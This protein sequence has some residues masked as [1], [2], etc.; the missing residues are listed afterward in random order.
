MDIKKADFIKK[1]WG[2]KPCKHPQLE[3]EYIMGSSTGDYICVQCGRVVDES[4]LNSNGVNNT[5]K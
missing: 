3:K 1:Q 4:D 2:N 5:Q